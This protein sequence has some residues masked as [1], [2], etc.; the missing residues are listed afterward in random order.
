MTKTARALSLILLTGAALAPAVTA[1]AAPPSGG[2]QSATD[3]LPG[4]LSP[5]AAEGVLGT[6]LHPAGISVPQAALGP[7]RL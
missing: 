5:A 6:L 3:A 1:Q 2:L 7:A 4:M